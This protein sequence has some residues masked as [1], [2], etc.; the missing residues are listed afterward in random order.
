M[1]MKRLFAALL[2]AWLC[3]PATLPAQEKDDAEKRLERLER[4]AQSLRFAIE[5]AEQRSLELT[6]LME[7]QGIARYEKIRYTSS[8]DG[9]TIPAHL[10]TP[11]KVAPAGGGAGGRKL[12]SLIWIHGGVHGHLD[13]YYWRLIREMLEEG[14]IILAPEYRGSTHHGADLYDAI[15]YGGMEVEDC[16]SGRD[17][18]VEMH[19]NADPNRVGIIGWSH[20]GFITMHA[21][22]RAPEKFKVGVNVVGVSDLVERMGY[23][24]E[25]YRRTFAEQKGFGGYADEKL[26]RYIERSPAHQAHRLQTPLLIHAATN[27]DDVRIIEITHLIDALKAA[28]KKFEYEIY[29][30]PPGGHSF[31]RI[32][33]KTAADSW[34]K[35]KTFLGRYLK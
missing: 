26:E 3:F 29:Q 1:A 2:F 31:N 27:D 5:A 35:A 30:A 16:V 21:L 34:G 6:F 7:A 17:W 14:Y 4:Q 18:L 20:G 24:P 11:L 13:L 10:W 33:T 23:M 22:Y 8:A 12:P 15:D 9:R 19:P 25:S 28:G 32:N